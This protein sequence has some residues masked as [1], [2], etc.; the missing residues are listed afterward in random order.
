MSATKA[1]PEEILAFKWM[2][3]CS[4]M[5]EEQLCLF[6]NS[7]ACDCALISSDGK[8][9]G[10]HQVVLS[11]A[12]DFLRRILAEHPAHIE[13]CIHISDAD[14]Q[15]INA[16]LTFM[17]TG[18]THIASIQLNALLELC[19]TL[20]IKGFTQDGI[21]MKSVS[22]SS[23]TAT[24]QSTQKADTNIADTEN[25][26]TIHTIFV[27]AEQ[28][29]D[30]EHLEMDYEMVETSADTDY[31]EV[32][33]LD[34]DDESLQSREPVKNEMSMEDEFSAENEEFTFEIMPDLDETASST[35][36]ASSQSNSD[37]LKRKRTTGQR[38]LNSQIDIALNEVS[39]GKTIHRLSLEY[40]VPRS[41][42]YHRFRSD[43]HLKKNYRIERK[44]ALEQA[45]RSVLDENLSLMKASER[46]KVPKTAIWREVRKFESYNP[47]ASKEV[48]KERQE[49]QEEIMSGKSLTSI[50]AKYGIPLTTLHRDKKKLSTEG[51]LPEILRVRDRTENSEY[52][53][54]LEEALQKCR[55]GMSQYQAAKLYKIPKATMWRYAHTLVRADKKMKEEAMQRE[56]EK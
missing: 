37:T 56:A 21:Q 46:F 31:D 12:S 55:Q 6:N 38:S 48:T 3:H 7:A 40:N 43:E 34:D 39:K 11:T 32:E 26:E 18:E 52:S 14:E 41:T 47:V 5:I 53:Q 15:L 33:Y 30:T 35:D 36:A 13:P 17:Y 45:V 22:A 24:N 4:D 54:R 28:D 27:E 1:P 8:R 23:R 50:S 2:E 16:L 42:L 10:A 9:I 25:I 19:N 29:D 20:D 51:K 44:C 49:A